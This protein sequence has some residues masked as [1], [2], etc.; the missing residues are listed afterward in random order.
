MR[1]AREAQRNCPGG[2]RLCWTDRL[3]RRLGN[4]D[5]YTQKCD[6]IVRHVGWFKTERIAIKQIR[7]WS[8]EPEMVFDIVAIELHDGSRRVWFDY[9]DDLLELLRQRVPECEANN[10]RTLP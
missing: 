9:D 5:R 6:E 4:T 8:V 2:V 3:K 1:R 10:D 7:N